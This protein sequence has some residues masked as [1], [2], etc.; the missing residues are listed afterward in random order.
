MTIDAKAF[1]FTFGTD[2]ND[3][4]DA[5]YLL[6]DMIDGGA[7]N[8]TIT[9]LNASDLLIGGLGNDTL[10]GLDGN[11][12]LDGGAGRDNLVGGAGNDLLRPDTGAIGNDVVDGGDGVDTLDFFTSAVVRGVRIDLGVTD[13]QGTR[14]A[15]ADLILNVENVTGSTFDDRLTGSTAD[16]MLIGGLGNDE[17]DGAGGNDNLIAG[18]GDD[19]VDGGAGSDD[20]SG[21]LGADQLTGGAGFDAFLYRSVGES[22]VT[23]GI[24]RIT[25]YNGAEDIIIVL[26]LSFVVNVDATRF[27]GSADFT[28]SGVSEIRVT[29]HNGV[30]LVE[31]DKNGNGGIDM[32]FEV[33]GT[34]LTFD[35]FF[36]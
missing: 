12:T 13:V 31:I 6:G 17:L 7:G 18:T 2:G 14:G 36:F 35:D 29:D 11:D 28:S 27:I 32:T 8:D 16:N 23:Q 22:S 5:Q 20:I 21:G 3:I 24:D 15:G 1:T 34:T 30:Q 19:R 26:P 10:L 25:D 33:V 4:I 9:G